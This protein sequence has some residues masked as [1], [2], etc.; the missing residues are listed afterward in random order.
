MNLAELN[1]LSALEL[2]PEL[3][4]CCGCKRWS[5]KLIAGRPF[6]SQEHLYQSSDQIWSKLSYADWLEAFNH[7]PKIGDLSALKAK[8]ASTSEW[9]AGEQ[10][11]VAL[12]DDKVIEALATGNDAYEKK[13]GYI[14]IVCATGK[15]AAE[16]LA[17]LQDRLANCAEDEIKIAMQEQ[18]KIT[19]LRLEKLMT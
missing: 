7:H 4:R 2:L 5:E 13:F 1:N 8:F 15:S 18:N 17:L 19:R 6:R 3:G 14:F 16:M 12:A 9:A 10:R 11:G